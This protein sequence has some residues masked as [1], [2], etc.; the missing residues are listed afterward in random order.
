MHILIFQSIL[1]QICSGEKLA[2]AAGDYVWYLDGCAVFLP[3]SVSQTMWDGRTTCMWYE[4]HACLPP[5]W[6]VPG[7]DCHFTC[8][9]G[10]I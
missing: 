7:S 1:E 5:Y 6:L 10:N 2:E 3:S 4:W 9:H 8:E